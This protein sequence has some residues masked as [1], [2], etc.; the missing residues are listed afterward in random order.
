MGMQQK[1]KDSYIY[2]D[3]VDHQGRDDR[4]EGMDL[5]TLAEKLFDMAVACLGVGIP[6]LSCRSLKVQKS[7]IGILRILLD[8][9][10]MKGD[11][12]VV[13]PYLL[14]LDEV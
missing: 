4:P 6:T 12:L 1:N 13:R 8:K 2:H 11:S 7:V 5:P 9:L 10:D 14:F 3:N